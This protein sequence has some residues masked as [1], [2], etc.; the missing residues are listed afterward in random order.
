MISGN[1]V[2]HVSQDEGGVYSKDSVRG[3]YN[4]LTEKVTRFPVGDGEVSKTKVS[5]DSE[6]YF[7]I[8]IFQYGLAAYDLYLLNN[9]SK[10]LSSFLACADWAVSNQNADGSWNTFDYKSPDKPY[11]AMAQGEAISLLVRA[12]IET[13]DDKY[14]RSASL[15]KDFMLIPLSDGGT[16]EY[17]D[18]EVYLYEH[19]GMPPI[20][21]GW[22]F[23]LWG[24]FDYSKHTGDEDV[25]RLLNAT[26]NTLKKSLYLY[27]TGF[28]S[29]YDTSSRIASPFYHSL[30]IAQLN[31][32]Y[33]LFGDE[34]YNYY[35]QKW[36][37]YEKSFWKP[38]F[39]FIKKALQKIAEWG[40]SI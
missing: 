29:R 24:L 9:D 13:D 38:K 26:L 10:M 16:T 1:S 27:D 35:A 18:D 28:W 31:V 39:A 19:C 4:N 14:I 30:H 17:K 36:A 20:L 5:S 33:D 22:I 15:A 8:A 2:H 12:H 6:I 40:K 34:I 21:N 23:S 3:Y 7:P 32:M 37:G 25:T 11:S